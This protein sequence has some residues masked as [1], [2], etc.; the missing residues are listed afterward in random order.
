VDVGASGGIQ[1]EWRSA[2]KYLKVV[3]FEPDDRAYA[4]LLNKTKSNSEI[5]LNTG[6]YRERT[7]LDL[8]LTK[9]QQASSLLRPNRKLLDRFHSDDLLHIQKIIKVK[10][11]SLDNQVNT[12]KIVDVD[13]IKLDTQGSELFIL[14]GSALILR[15]KTFGLEI[16]VEFAQLY[17]NQP[18]FPDIDRFMRKFGF[19]LFDLH[20]Y[21]WKKK[22]GKRLGKPKGQIVYADSLYLRDIESLEHILYNTGSNLMRKVKVLKAISIC[23]LYGYFDYALEIIDRTGRFFEKREKEVIIRKLKNNVQISSRIP[24]F[25]GRGRIANL[26][27]GFWKMFAMCNNRYLAEKKLGNR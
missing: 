10:V 12:N 20:P 1:R 5:Y 2:L 6:L 11:D 21:Y 14:Q 22:I 15:D 27:Y 7:I 23:I 4:N 18:L 25:R 24:D 3:G 19:Q 17:E 13:F 9:R 16:E 8:Y 26:F